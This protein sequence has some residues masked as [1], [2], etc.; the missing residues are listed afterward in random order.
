MAIPSNL[1]IVDYSRRLN[2]WIDINILSIFEEIVRWKTKLIP[3]L[4]FK[5]ENYRYV[6]EFFKN[7]RK[8]GRKKIFQQFPINEIYDV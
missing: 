2:K 7:E 4:N 1:I 8:R 5:K 3:S 6:S